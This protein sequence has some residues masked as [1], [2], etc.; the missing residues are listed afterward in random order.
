VR[1][2]LDPLPEWSED[3]G[4]VFRG[5]GQV[6]DVDCGRSKSSASLRRRFPSGQ[7]QTPLTERDLVKHAKVDA[8]LFERLSQLAFDREF[9]RIELASRTKREGCQLLSII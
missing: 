7:R 1:Q 9:L 5:K 6:V 2:V 4:H 3:V 8:E